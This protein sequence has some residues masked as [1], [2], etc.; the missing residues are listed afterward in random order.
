MQLAT[1]PDPTA[2]GTTVSESPPLAQFRE[3]PSPPGSVQGARDQRNQ[4]APIEE[5]V[6]PTP[7]AAESAEPPASEQPPHGRQTYAQRAWHCLQGP[8]EADKVPFDAV[9]SPLFPPVTAWVMEHVDRRVAACIRQESAICVDSLPV[10]SDDASAMDIVDLQALERQGRKRLQ[11][12]FILFTTLVLVLSYGLH[13]FAATTASG[14]PAILSCTD[15]FNKYT[16]GF[17]ASR[18]GI[19]NRECNKPSAW[20]IVRCPG[21]CARRQVYPLVT[22]VVG[23]GPYRVDSRVCTAAVHAGLVGEDGGC[24]E[25]RVAGAAATFAPSTRNGVVALEFD[26]WFPSTLELRACPG[27]S[28]FCTY[29]AWWKLLITNLMLLM[30][31]SLL[32]PSRIV[33]FWS[34]VTLLYWYV[35]LASSIGAITIEE[36]F[37]KMGSYFFFCL[38]AHIFLWNVGGAKDFL[39]DTASGVPFDV[40]LLELL[41][42]LPMLHLHLVAYFVGD[43]DLNGSLFK[44]W[45]PALVYGIGTLALLPAICWLL[46]V[47]YKAKCLHK[48][49]GMLVSSGISIIILTLIFSTVNWGLHLHHYFSS[50]VGFL[51]ARGT[52]RT[53][54]LFRAFC[55]GAIIN[56]LCRWGR[57]ADIPIW[58][59]GSG[60]LPDQGEVDSGAKYTDHSRQVLW[61]GV[62]LMPNSYAVNL[63]WARYDNL[64]RSCSRPPQAPVADD[65]VYV[66]EMN[67]VEVYRGK[68]TSWTFPF[69]PPTLNNQFHRKVYFRV[70]TVSRSSSIGVISVSTVLAV[71]PAFPPTQVYYNSSVDVCDRAVLLQSQPVESLK[72]FI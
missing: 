22:Q 40:L 4:E 31:L 59:E 42:T 32:R 44:D 38:F 34:L 25:A 7:P 11:V 8:P 3:L 36:V 26:T 17:G 45:R 14:K 66:V 29:R 53:A 35:A 60:W 48:F 49:L 68:N 72:G 15:Y 65:E 5:P 13:L 37:K 47:W 10:T 41:P 1:Q 51:F 18:C 50:S 30:F 71:Q 61:T 19:D 52:S 21:W 6:Q 67:H 2:G 28:S 63:S 64:R 24:L 54:R 16:S 20:V 58:Q 39:S 33:F 9:A 55:L 23:S 46:R 62:E 56:G 27:G 69:P 57:P 12:V 70:G 43:Y